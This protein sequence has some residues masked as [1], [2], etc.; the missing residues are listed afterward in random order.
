MVR[1]KPNRAPEA[2][3]IIVFGPGVT[4]DTKANTASAIRR[5]EVIVVQHMVKLHQINDGIIG[6]TGLRV[7]QSSVSKSEFTNSS[8]PVVKSK[9]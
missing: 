2:N 3:S 1:A 6:G 8:D 5:L 9:T 7:I 4:Q